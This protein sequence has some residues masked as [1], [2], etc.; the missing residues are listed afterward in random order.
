MGTTRSARAVWEGDLFEGSGRIWTESSE[1]LVGMP[2]TWASRAEEPQGR[3][4]PEELLAAA[5]A[6]CFSMALSNELAK[7]GH[8]PER[9]DVRATASFD[10]TD[11]GWRVT[12]MRLEVTGRVPGADDEAFQRAAEAAGAGCPISRALE[13]NVRVEVAAKLEG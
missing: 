3:T 12:T 1:V 6:A 9:L 4:S 10:K 7:A 5:H 2:V 13:G 8:P 11:A